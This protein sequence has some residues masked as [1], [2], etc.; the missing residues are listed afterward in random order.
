MASTDYL[1]DLVAFVFALHLFVEVTAE[2]SEI[3]VSAS[4]FSMGVI[5][6]FII[7]VTYAV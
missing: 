7:I 2:A 5:T 4:P 6:K 1:W 3:S